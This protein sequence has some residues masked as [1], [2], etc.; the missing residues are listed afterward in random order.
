MNFVK[1]AMMSAVFAG[2]LIVG[3]TPPTQAQAFAGAEW[4]C[5]YDRATLKLLY[6][7]W[8][9]SDATVD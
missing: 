9:T 8:E 3:Y 7:Q 2:S 4:V 1:V 6:C 5:Y